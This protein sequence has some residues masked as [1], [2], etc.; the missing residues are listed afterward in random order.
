[1]GDY[2]FMAAFSFTVVG[3]GLLASLRGGWME[4]PGLGRRS[5]P[6]SGVTSLLYADADS[7]LDA[8]WVAP[9]VGWG[10]AFVIA[11]ERSRIRTSA[12]PTTTPA[13]DNPSP[14]IT[15]S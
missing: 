12:T 8:F 10:T 3:V 7:S 6:R 11:A 9:A 13:S 1:M 15:S 2:G 4:A 5:P 14:S